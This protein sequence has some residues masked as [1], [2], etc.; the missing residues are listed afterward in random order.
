MSTTRAAW[1]G[2]GVALLL[3]A[4]AFAVPPVL[5]WEV[6]P[7]APRSTVS[8]E[9]PP[10]H[11]FWRP[12]WWGPGTLPAVLV[13]AL[14]VR[15]GPGLA[16]RLSWGRL[17]A[18]SYAA[19]LAWLLSLAL[20]D[21]G[22]GLGRAIGDR[23]EYLPAARAVTDVPG[24]LHGYVDRIPI[25]SPEAWPTQPAGHPPLALLFFVGLDR[26][27]LG[28]PTVAGVVVTALAAT[29]VV[30]V[31]VTLRALGAEEAAR[32]AAPLLVLTPAAVFLAVSADAVFTAVGAW[33]LAC[34]AIAATAASRR[35]ATAW[36][37]LAGLLLGAA[38][39]MS[40]G[41][42]LLGVLALAVLL[43]ARSWL[44]LPVAAATALA[45][46]L[47]FAAAGFAWWEAIGV[48][49]ERYWDGIAADRPA[50]YWLWGNLAALLVCA[51][52]L[53]GA[54]LAQTAV[55]RRPRAVALLV[56]AAALTVLLADASRMS[57]A[58]VERIWLPF[59]PW[60]TISVALLPERWRRWGLG[61]QVVWALAVQ[62]LL[63]TS[64]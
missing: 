38:V 9:V 60:L 57:K 56:A 34:L 13:A 17:L 49:H 39:M 31:L 54:G 11:G 47:G 12:T 43:A 26:L 58:E 23:Y 41:L 32:A 63:Y 35:G 24:L 5:G 45:V 50:S 44:P 64:W 10:L 59:V 52:P 8:G 28:D 62:H 14:G 19:G 16:R 2:L 37:A 22:D 7:R 21:G 29:A 33:G 61:L 4:L 1:V 18:A 27:G 51:G 53:L 36:A 30:A 48:L 40:Y 20:V 15:F 42:P 46:V 3:V 55:A 25:D 6:W